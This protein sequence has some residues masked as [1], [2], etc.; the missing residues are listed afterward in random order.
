MHR[1]IGEIVA[2]VLIVL[3]ALVAI[4]GLSWIYAI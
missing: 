3:P 4:M 1:T 2:G